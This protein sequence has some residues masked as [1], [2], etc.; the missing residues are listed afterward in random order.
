[1]CRERREDQLIQQLVLVLD[2]RQRAFVN[3]GQLLGHAHAVG[4]AAERAQLLALLQA[5]DANLE[6]LVEV[7]AGDAEEAD[8]LEQRQRLVVNLR[9][10]ALV[11]VEKRQLPIDVVLGSL[12]IH[13]EHGGDAVSEEPGEYYGPR[14]ACVTALPGVEFSS[15]RRRRRRQSPARSSRASSSA[16]RDLNSAR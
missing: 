11:E 2:Q 13:V 6:E 8:A 3:R 1:M 16:L 10:H 12:E 4:P 5:G 7:G 9:E 15:W 14:A